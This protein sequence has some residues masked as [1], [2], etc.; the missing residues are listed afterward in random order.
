[1]N[2]L[3]SKQ[4]LDRILLG[5]DVEDEL[6]KLQEIGTL[7]VLFPEVQAMVGA[8]GGRGKDDQ[9]ALPNRRRCRPARGGMV[10]GRFRS[11]TGPREGFRR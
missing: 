3:P 10:A 9:P 4:E 7:V 2:L 8:G 6:E 1:M 5:R 11:G